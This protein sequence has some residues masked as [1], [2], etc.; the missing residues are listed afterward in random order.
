MKHYLVYPRDKKRGAKAKEVNAMPFE[1]DSGREFQSPEG[2]NVFVN[3]NGFVEGLFGYRVMT[4]NELPREVR[5]SLHLP[6][7]GEQ[8]S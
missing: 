6:L 4:E 2:W 3:D 7:D 1:L 8:A 5:K